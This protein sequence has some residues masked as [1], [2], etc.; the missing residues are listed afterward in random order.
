MWGKN[1]IYVCV[2]LTQ[3]RYAQKVCAEMRGKMEYDFRNVVIDGKCE[4]QAASEFSETAC[5]LAF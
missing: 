4:K 1:E 5:L 2:H 3:T